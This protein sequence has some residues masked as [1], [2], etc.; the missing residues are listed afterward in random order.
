MSNPTYPV[1]MEKSLTVTVIAG[2]ITMRLIT[3]I[4]NDLVQPAVDML[5]FEKLFHSM[6]L[7]Y[8]QNMHIVKNSKAVNPITYTFNFGNVLRELIT[9][10]ALMTLLYLIYIKI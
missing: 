2:M 10:I 4:L 1:F 6:T 5:I 8:D 9:W 3:S 7:T